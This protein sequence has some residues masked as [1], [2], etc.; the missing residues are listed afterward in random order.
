MSRI[1]HQDATIVGMTRAARAEVVAPR[2]QR[3]AALEVRDRALADQ[4]LQQRNE[5]AALQSALLGQQIHELAARSRTSAHY[6]AVHAPAE[7]RCRRG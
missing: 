6:D 1:A 4:I 2:R 5:A 7:Q 3:L